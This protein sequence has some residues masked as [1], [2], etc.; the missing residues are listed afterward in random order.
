MSGIDLDSKLTAILQAL[1]E[2]E[3]ILQH[4]AAGIS[5]VAL[6]ALL[7]AEFRET[8][9]SGH[10]YDRK[11]AL[12]ALEQGSAGEPDDGAASPQ[13]SELRCLR[14]AEEVYLLTY[15]LSHPDR[16]TRRSSIWRRIDG[17][18]RI[19]YHQGTVLRPASAAA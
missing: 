11:T 7:D 6:E 13:M 1:R 15:L 8:G 19:V 18:W 17:E 2:R 10:L 3:A 14:L 16:P 5:S 9:A 12:Q 4:P